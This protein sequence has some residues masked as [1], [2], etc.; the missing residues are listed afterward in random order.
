MRFRSEPGRIVAM[1]EDTPFK[2]A[3]IQMASGTNVNANLLA[4]LALPTMERLSYP[5]SDGVEVEGW[6]LEPAV[7]QAPY[8]TVL[9]VHSGPAGGFGH[10]FEGNAHQ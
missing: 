8:P 2:A 6:L 1:T 4:E 9:Y 5:S 7:G 10:I 3:A